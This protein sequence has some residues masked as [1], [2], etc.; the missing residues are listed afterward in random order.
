MPLSDRQ[1]D[2]DLVL[3]VKNELVK[4]WVD[5]VR[6][7]VHVSRGQ[8]E[9]RGKLVFEGFG[10]MSDSEMQTRLI[11][12]DPAVRAVQGVVGVQWRLKDWTKQGTRWVKR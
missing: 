11:I 9:L 10:H 4:R 7:E 1:N 5:L 8:V 3:R 2:R 12:L 6:L